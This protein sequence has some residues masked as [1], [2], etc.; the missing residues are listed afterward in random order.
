MRKI[1]ILLIVVVAVG[2]LG[3]GVTSAEAQETSPSES[4]SFGGQAG[5]Q[6]RTVGGTAFTMAADVDHRLNPKVGVGVFGF[7]SSAA[8]LT[9]FAAAAV[10]RYR[11]ELV[12]HQFRVFAGTGAVLATYEGEKSTGIYFPI[13]V[14]EEVHWKGTVFTGTI[15][16]NLH[17][18]RFEDR[19]RWDRRSVALIFGVRI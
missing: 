5:V 16:L 18:L 12:G 6:A 2:V 7:A 1:P 9:E 17:E 4:W 13:G 8:G 15:L 14:T 11:F 3:M 19:P 10:G